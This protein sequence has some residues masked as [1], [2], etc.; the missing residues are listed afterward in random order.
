MPTRWGTFSPSRYRR[1]QVQQRNTTR[2][3]Q[4]HIRLRRP[5]GSIN[6]VSG[7]EDVNGQAFSF[8]GRLSVS[9]RILILARHQITHNLINNVLK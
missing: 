5:F 1:D 8:S 3:A 2:A 7:R 4:D 9:Q 6:A